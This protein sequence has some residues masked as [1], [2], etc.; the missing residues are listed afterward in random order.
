MALTK[1]NAKDCTIMVDGVYI[2]QV[3][4]DMV[5]FEKD[6]AF[7]ETSVGA[8]GDV[9]KS[10]INNPLHKITLTIQPTSPQK[11]FLLNKC[12]SDEEFSVWVVNKKLGE[13]FGG[14]LCSIPEMPQISR[15]STSEDLEFT[16]TV[17][18]GVLE[19]TE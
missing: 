18:D 7:Y 8:Q 4:E 16:F 14:T 11:A 13:R 1:Y 5:T 12:G 3:G 17:F 2:T 6:E 15:G 9:V 10:T 19:A